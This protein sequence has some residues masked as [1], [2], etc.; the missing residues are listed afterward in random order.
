MKVIFTDTHLIAIREPEDK[1]FYGV[2][3][4]KGES[5]LLYAIQQK[6][7]DLG[8]KVIKKRMWKDG[9]MVGDLQQYLRTP[10]GVEPSWAAYNATWQVEGLEQDW[11]TVGRVELDLIKDIWSP[12]T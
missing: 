12:W 8:H 10:K 11:N 2:R 3:Q 5:N 9:H 6:L 7:K 1:K 4:A